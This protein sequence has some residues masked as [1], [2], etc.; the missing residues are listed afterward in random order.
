[1]STEGEGEGEGGERER[2]RGRGRG[3]R[4]RER[5]RERESE[6]ESESESVCACVYA[7]VCERYINW[8]F[9][10]HL[11]DRETTPSLSEDSTGLARLTTLIFGYL[12]NVHSEV[13]GSGHNILHN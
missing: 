13:I 12:P 8:T 4:E 2:E 5:E 1:M 9:G 7:C 10:N 11:M 6:S 3:G